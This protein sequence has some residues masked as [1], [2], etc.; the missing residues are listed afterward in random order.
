MSVYKSESLPFL[1]SLIEA[2][3]LRILIHLCFSF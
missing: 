1:R 2:R 3:L